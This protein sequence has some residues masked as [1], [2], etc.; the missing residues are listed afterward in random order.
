MKNSQIN[1]RF[2]FLTLLVLVAAFSRLIPHQPNFAPIG[3][4]ALFGAAHFKQ[5]FLALLIPILAMWLS[6]L[7]LN[8][9]IY[10][11]YFDGFAWFYSGF[12]YTYFAFIV[13]GLVGF[14]LLKKIK[15]MNL[16]VASFAASIL[17]YL[18]SNFGVWASGTMY[19][20][21]ISGLITCFTAGLPFIKNT[22]MGDLMYGGA[23]FGIFELAQHRYPILQS[24]KS[25]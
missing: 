4:M 11:Q 21:N 2:G 8:N 17:F 14:F 6:D 3:A 7:A 18:I 20:K 22:L 10:S 12:Y 24:Q 5:K 25:I 13:I 9:I 1:I 23:L 16:L 19:P 15:P